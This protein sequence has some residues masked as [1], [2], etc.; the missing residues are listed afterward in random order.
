VDFCIVNPVVRGEDEPHTRT[1]TVMM[2]W[3]VRPVSAEVDEY[4]MMM[5]IMM[6]NGG[7][8]SQSHFVK[9]KSHMD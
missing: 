7:N 2:F 1:G 8:L 9:N 3:Q 5:M 6:T 4:M